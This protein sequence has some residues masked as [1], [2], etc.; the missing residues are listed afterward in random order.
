MAFHGLFVGIDRYA[1][2]EASWLSCAAND[3]RALHA[4]FLDTFRGNASLLLD[5]AAT[6]AAVTE[7]LSSLASVAPDDLVV[8]T[9]SGHGTETHELATYDIDLSDLDNTSISLARLGEL[10][11]RI[12][13][14]RLLI[15]LDCCFS[16]GMGAKAIQ[17]DFAERD[18]RSVEVKLEEISGHGRVILTASSATEKAYERARS[19]HGLLTLHM[20]EALLGPNEIREGNR[21]SVL[22]LL[23]YVVRRVVDAAQ[24]IRRE[25]HPT[26]KGA[27]EGDYTWPVFVRGAAY[28]T[29]FPEHADPVATAEI[30]SLAA[31]G[32]PQPILEAW[33]SDIPKL[34]ALQ[35]DAINEYGILRG[36]HLVASAPTSS[37]KTMLGEL[38]AIR[39]ALQRRRTLFLMPLKALVNDKLRQFDRVYGPFGIR[40]IEA[41][42]E[43]ADIRPLMRSQFDI[44]L[45]TY[46]KFAAIALAFPHVLEQ[47]GTVVVDEVQMI[48]DRGRGANL[49]FVLTLLRMKRAVGVEPQVIALS[50]VI[51]DT[52]GLERWLGGRLLR[53]TERPVALDEGILCADGRFRYIDGDSGAERHDDG[54]IR[55]QHGDGKHRDWVIPLVQRLMKEGKQVIVFRETTGETRHGARYLAEALDLPPAKEALAAMP[56]GDPSQASGHLRDVLRGGVA[57]HNSHLDPEE[58]RVIE[59]QFRAPNATLRVIVATTTLAMGVN[60]PASAVI[61]VGLEHPTGAG[62]QPYSVAEYKNLAGRAGRLGYAERGSSYLIAT[63]A[64]EEHHYWDHY[65]SAA[66]EDLQSRFLDADARTL[67]L[68]VIVAASRAAG[69]GITGEEIIDFLEASFGAFQLQQVQSGWGWDT[70]QLEQAVENLRDHG[71]ITADAEGRFELT[72]LG[73]LA[74]ESGTEVESVIRAVHALRQ[75]QATEVNDPTLITLAQTTVELDECHFPANRKSTQ[76]E[77]QHWPGELRRQKVSASA[78]AALRRNVTQQA[79]ETLRAKKA[80]AC[81]YYV[82]GM[83]MEDIERAMTQFGGAFDGAAG[84]IR[85]VTARTCDVLRM[86]ARVAEILH[87]DIDASAQL[88]RLLV[89]LDLGIPGAVAEL[90]SYAGRSLER[91]DY[92]Q[93][94]EAGLVTFESLSDPKNDGILEKM[95]GKPKCGLLRMALEQWRRDARLAAQKPVQALPPYEP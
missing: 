28:K 31:F 84:P 61:I 10:C 22:S 93:L 83:P 85:S 12:P 35:R 39:G 47:A 88:S 9:F 26:I 48:A 21:V 95:L 64:R 29:A 38:A 6:R 81:L 71:L 24:L 50:A 44:A 62:P 92:R 94:M 82:S 75:M 77:P 72:E 87:E 60:T 34:N 86:I 45:L 68:R 69:E 8:I 16:G 18:I 11:A 19:G 70:A 90:G 58:K 67:I 42:G 65:V 3:A 5:E 53:R 74:G 1:S 57:F 32:F 14:R 54:Y 51:G 46:E 27:F 56:A 36:S 17:V 20:I 41:T 4:L 80:V 66:P 13:A 59:E 30:G 7:A 89:R 78:L 37:G 63:D 79:Q 2:P 52:N 55:R 33:A 73:R 23:E 40:T 76:K 91:G 49:E 15:V 25:Q 43:T